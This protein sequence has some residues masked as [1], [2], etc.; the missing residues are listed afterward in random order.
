MS[1]SDDNNEDK[2]NQEEE[3]N[4]QNLSADGED[5]YADGDFNLDNADDFFAEGGSM[6]DQLENVSEDASEA[7]SADS[8]D[9]T[10]TTE[11]AES[12]LTEGDNP[13]GTYTE[14][15]S[16]EYIED[17]YAAVEEIPAEES[18]QPADTD[19]LQEEEEVKPKLTLW[20][21][22]A[23]ADRY[24]ML[25]LLSLLLLCVGV[26]MMLIRL[27]DYKFNVKAKSTEDGFGLIEIQQPLEYKF[28]EIQQEKVS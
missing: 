23:S 10:E 6:A 17:P 13:E 4:Q 14:D 16:G 7:D 25:L 3:L 15:T 21:K 5:E 18:E 26:T 9:F 2:L 27:N 24:N 12:E 19:E 11:T 22:I 1:N 20:Q 28:L 8:S